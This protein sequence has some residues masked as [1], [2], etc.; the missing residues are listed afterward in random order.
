M[1]VVSPTPYKVECLYSGD[2]YASP[3]YECTK[4]MLVREATVGDEVQ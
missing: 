1:L 2:N 4:D 3:D